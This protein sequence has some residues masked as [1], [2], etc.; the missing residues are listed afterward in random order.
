MIGRQPVEPAAAAGYPLVSRGLTVRHAVRAGRVTLTV[1]GELDLRSADVLAQVIA[2]EIDSGPAELMIDIA[3]VSFL[4]SA[5]AGVLIDGHRPAHQR[6]VRYQV[7]GARRTPRR[8]LEIL[9]GYHLLT[10]G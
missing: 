6:Q 7:S 4:D 10:P 5:G 2:A 1:A 9:G 3:G 8:V